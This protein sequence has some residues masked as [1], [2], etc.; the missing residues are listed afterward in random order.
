M[1]LVIGVVIPFKKTALPT[2]ATA[3]TES[4][5]QRTTSPRVAALMGGRF[6]GVTYTSETESP[7]GIAGASASGGGGA[8]GPASGAAPPAPPAPPN[9]DP[10]APPVLPLLLLLLLLLVAAAAPP[11]PA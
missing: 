8:S 4:F 3:S 5:A 6:A 7:Q 2:S 10:P 11:C 9:D 1:P